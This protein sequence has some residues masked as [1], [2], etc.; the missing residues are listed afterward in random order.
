MRPLKREIE[1]Y[2]QNPRAETILTE[3]RRDGMTVRI[4][5]AGVIS[6]S[7]ARSRN[8]QAKTSGME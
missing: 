4:S 8:S 3:E 7:M 5:G 6:P 1:R 2:V